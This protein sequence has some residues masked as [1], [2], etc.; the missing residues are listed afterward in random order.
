MIYHGRGVEI[1]IQA[2]VRQHVQQTLTVGVVELECRK[3]VDKFVEEE[4]L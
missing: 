2:E 3:T 1:E 4:V